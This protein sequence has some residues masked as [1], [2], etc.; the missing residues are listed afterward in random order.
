MQVDL[1]S[2]PLPEQK[3]DSHRWRKLFMLIVMHVKDR[4]LA[5]TLLCRMH[6]IR[7]IGTVLRR[8][9]H[10]LKFVP[11]LDPEGAWPDMA[12]YDDIKQRYLLPYAAELKHLIGLVAEQTE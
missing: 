3:F 4:E 7:S 1:L 8:D 6:S 12:F 9:M 5:Y 10:G 11:L 2:D